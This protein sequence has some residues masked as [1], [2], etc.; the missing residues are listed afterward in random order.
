MD[1]YLPQFVA[2][3]IALTGA[4]VG[5]LVQHLLA[6]KQIRAQQQ[7][8]AREK[9]YMELLRHLSKAKVASG[10]LCE[11]Y[12]EPESEHNDYSRDPRFRELGAVRDKS[13]AATRELA[14]PAAVFLSGQ[15]IDA[16]KEL[17][18]KTWDASM[19]SVHVG[20]YIET[21]DTLIA[22]AESEV[23]KAARTHLSN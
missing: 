8:T 2:A 19:E 11:Y 7:W 5:A 6:Q 12:M 15:A 1:E 16:L 18:L 20:E 14:R 10:R 22:R 21:L 23:L 3:A 4:I 9:H 17:E 13:L